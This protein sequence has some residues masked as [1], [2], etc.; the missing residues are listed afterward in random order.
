MASGNGHI[1]G[2]IN[3]VLKSASSSGVIIETEADKEKKRQQ[4][5]DAIARWVCAGRSYFGEAFHGKLIALVQSHLEEE[6]AD[7]QDALQKAREEAA[8]A[9]AARMG[10]RRQRRNI[11]RFTE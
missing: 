3:G 8:N 5:T 9:K 4:L 10:N 11:W 1:N 7:Q 2:H 6:M